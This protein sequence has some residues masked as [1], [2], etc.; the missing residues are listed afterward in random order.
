VR[1]AWLSGNATT[2]ANTHQQLGAANERGCP[3]N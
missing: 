1:S 2:I 3:L